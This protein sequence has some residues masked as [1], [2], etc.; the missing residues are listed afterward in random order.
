[1]AS[2]AS[3]EGPCG[4]PIYSGDF[5][6]LGNMVFADPDDD[7]LFEPDDGERGLDGVT[8]ELWSDVDFDGV[9]EPNGDDATG[10]ECT[11]TTSDG[12]HYWFHDVASGIYFVALPGGGVPT[13]MVSTTG[14]STSTTT[15][16]TDDGA[17]T[18]GFVAVT[19]A[20]TLN[21]A[22]DQPVGEAAPG[23]PAGSDESAANAAT[24]VTNDTDSNLSIDFGLTQTTAPACLKIGN[25]VWLDLDNDGIAEAGEEGLDGVTVELYRANDDGGPTGALLQTATTANG[26]YYLFG[27]VDAGTYVIVVPAS[28]FAD[29]G[30]LAGLAPS[31]TGPAGD[32]ANDGAATANGDVVSAP[33][34]IAPANAPVN[35]PDKPT[36]PGDNDFDNPSDA[37]VNTEVDFGFTGLTIGN[38]VFLDS[39]TVDGIQ[40]PTEPGV[41]GVTVELWASDGTDPVGDSP[42]ATTTTDAEGYYLF[43]GLYAGDYIVRIPAS[44]FATAGPLANHVSTSGNGVAPDPDD[45]ASDRDDNGDG[46][47]AG[48]VDSRPVSLS[49]GDEP[50][51]EADVASAMDSSPSDDNANV[52][53]DF[54]FVD[55]QTLNPEVAAIGDRVW[56]DADADGIQDAGEKGVANV[57][58]TLRDANGNAVSTTFTDEDGN[59]RFDGLPPGDYTVCFDLGTVPAGLTPTGSNAGDDDAADSDAKVDGCTETVTLTAGEENMTIDLGVYDGGQSDLTIDK[60]GAYASGRVTWTITITNR[61]SAA[62]TDNI[63]I[64]DVIPSDVVF[65][66]AVGDGF[67]CSYDTDSRTASCSFANGLAAGESAVLTV[68]TRMQSATDCVVSNTAT[69]A[70]AGDSNVTNNSDS[71]TLNDACVGTTTTTAAGT[72]TTIKATVKPR[73]PVTGGNAMVFVSLALALAFAGWKLQ[74]VSSR[75][76][77]ETLHDRLRDF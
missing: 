47:A 42:L 35:E 52:T 69:V 28:N 6:R 4:T 21:T 36:L 12:G 24:E 32:Q 33:V 67:A 18:A 57:S 29:D 13:G 8:V 65:E 63:Q 59:Y 68:V 1:M 75:L 54:G 23:D 9:F 53:V 40:N 71:A 5:N 50:T 27:C 48:P 26:G 41:A 38:R 30:A 56:I 51:G 49:A 19:S 25:R 44:N 45:D 60:S 34:Q 46:P 72:T 11:T 62:L 31:V 14:A 64:R 74:S 7:G 43:K 16:H 55:S 3:A 73:L 76:K 39:V 10:R 20:I 22:T 17:P 66:S 15:D 58:V 77:T 2:P 70:S 37:D 61:G